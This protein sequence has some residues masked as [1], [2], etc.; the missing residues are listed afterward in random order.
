MAVTIVFAAPPVNINASFAD[1]P[2][3]Y[4]LE[5]VDAK[6]THINTLYDQQVVLEKNIW[7][8]WD[9][10][11]DEGRLMGVGNYIARL[12]KNGVLIEKIALT[13]II[14]NASQSKP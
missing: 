6:G 1:G 8:T 14:P 7:I 13:W 5:I 2:W 4:R 3:V 9:G 12:S 11:N 10:T